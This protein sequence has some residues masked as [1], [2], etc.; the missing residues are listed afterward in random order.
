MNLKENSVDPD[1]KA[2]MCRLI[3]IYTVIDAMEDVSME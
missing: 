3:C 1:Q 2:C